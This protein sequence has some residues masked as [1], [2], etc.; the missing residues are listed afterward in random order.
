MNPAQKALWYIE[1][2]LGQSLG[3]EEIAEIAG[4]S[5]FH[6]IRAFAEIRAKSRGRARA[7]AL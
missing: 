2:H 7:R 3:L 4:V 6:L 5:C 1:S